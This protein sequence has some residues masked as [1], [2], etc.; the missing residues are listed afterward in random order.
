MK[1]L[2][3]AQKGFLGR[4]FSRHILLR[5]GL[6]FLMQFLSLA[7]TLLH[8]LSLT[9]VLICVSCPVSC[10]LVQ[11][12]LLRASSASS[13]PSPP[14]LCSKYLQ[15]P[16]IFL[17]GTVWQVPEGSPA[18]I[19]QLAW[20]V[21]TTTGASLWTVLGAVTFTCVYLLSS[22][23]YP[24]RCVWSLQLLLWH[25]CFKTLVHW[26]PDSRAYACSLYMCELSLMYVLDD[27]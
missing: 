18:H 13:D 19:Q 21:N 25:T 6:I 5:W 14:N 10:S 4:V 12:G 1:L 17:N 16:H 24:S 7:H 27:R 8:S 9:L 20:K 15:Q 23:L 3:Q 26:T 2:L 11:S 22:S